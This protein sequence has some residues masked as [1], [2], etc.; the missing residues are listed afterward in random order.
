MFGTMRI[1]ATRSPAL[2]I[3]PG[4]TMSWSRMPETCGLISTS[5]RGTT[6]PVATAF[7]MIVA[8]CALAVW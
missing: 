2:T 1:R 4:S 5:L 7:L 6:E 3:W 8:R